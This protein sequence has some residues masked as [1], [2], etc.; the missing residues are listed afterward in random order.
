MLQGNE[1]VA[2]LNQKT[3]EVLGYSKGEILGKNWFDNFVP[4]SSREEMRMY[5]HQL[6]KGT[7]SRGHLEQHVLT[8]NRQERI[9]GWHILPIKNENGVFYEAVFS[10]QDITD[11]KLV[12]ERYTR[13][14]SFPAFNPNPMVEVDFNRNVTYT[15]PA[16]KKVFPNIEKQ[17]LNQPFFGNWEAVKLAFKGKN[18]MDYSFGRE[19]KLG[20]H[21]YL[22]QFSFIPIGPRIRVIAINID[23]KK[24]A[25]E[26]LKVK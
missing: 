20:K 14:A 18:S 22:Q 17:G 23:D 3:C 25:E 19:I 2:D 11:R 1:H 8:K 13:L 24:R 12:E 4:T 26:D 15:N 6:L 16:T 7:L 9:I 21:W 10:G 5:F